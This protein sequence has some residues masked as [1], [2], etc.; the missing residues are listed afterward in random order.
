M[1]R[2]VRSQRGA[3]PLVDVALAVAVAAVIT[4]GTAFLSGGRDPGA[5]GYLLLAA[6]AA[7]MAVRR[8]APVAALATIVGLAVGYAAV[9]GPNVAFALPLGVG[10]YTV[11]DAGGW[12]VAVGGIAIV[13]LGSLLAGF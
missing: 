1:N 6:S 7:P 9:A 12:R 8:R 5:I 10:L 11:T 13:G 3:V 2:L 4:I